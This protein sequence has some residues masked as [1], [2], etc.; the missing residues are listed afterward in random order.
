MPKKGNF[1]S[2]KDSFE[3]KYVPVP[4]AGCWLWIGNQRQNGYGVITNAYQQLL[5]HR[6]AY[7]LYKSPIPK[8]LVVCHKCD[9]PCCV[10]PDHLFLGTQKE[11]IHDMMKKGRKR[12]QDGYT[13]F[14]PEDIIAIRADNRRHKLIAKDY[15][16]G[17][18][19][20][21]TI[22]RNETWKHV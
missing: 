12:V 3:D 17:R 8:G 4:E 6:V 10:N 18:S 14:K 15:G 7:E 5:A 21:S 9:T 20:I 16:C 1:K 22:K 11:N 2:L 13:Q 19:T